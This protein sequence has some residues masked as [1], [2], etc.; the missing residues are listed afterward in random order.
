MPTTTVT[1]KKTNAL[2]RRLKGAS[3]IFEGVG[4]EGSMA[5]KAANQSIVQIP[6]NRI[7]GYSVIKQST[8]NNS[9]SKL[10]AAIA[11]TA[12]STRRARVRV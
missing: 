3:L 5:Q 6:V 8:T 2:C 11:A 9:D 4:H 10:K 12:N 7:S 1:S